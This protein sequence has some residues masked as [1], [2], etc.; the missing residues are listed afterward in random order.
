MCPAM[1]YGRSENHN[2]CW[3]TFTSRKVLFA[4]STFR[5]SATCTNMNVGASGAALAAVVEAG[6]AAGAAAVVVGSFPARRH[7]EHSGRKK[8]PGADEVRKLPGFNRVFQMSISFRHCVISLM[9]FCFAALYSAS[10]MS[11]CL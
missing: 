5:S 4:G 1:R 6:P 11:P 2:V 9:I 8:K 7:N 3:F 10:V